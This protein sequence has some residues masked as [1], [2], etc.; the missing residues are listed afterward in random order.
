MAPEEEAEDEFSL[1]E[2]RKL[3]QNYPRRKLILKYPHF[4]IFLLW[5][6]RICKPLAWE[7]FF[8]I[9]STYLAEYYS[10]NLPGKP[11]DKWEAFNNQFQA[12][13]VKPYLMDKLSICDEKTVK[14]FADFFCK[15]TQLFDLVNEFC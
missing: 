3:I 9:I 12:E 11:T 4:S 7:E 8:M 1:M 2:I 5:V 14:K 6:G 13:P 10:K 15:W